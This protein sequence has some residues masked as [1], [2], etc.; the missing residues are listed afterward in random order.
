MGD[1]LSSCFFSPPWFDWSGQG[2]DERVVWVSQLFGERE[3]ASFVSFT[4]C[5]EDCVLPTRTAPSATSE[6]PIFPG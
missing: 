2:S 4:L 5:D 3:H 1:P 6:L